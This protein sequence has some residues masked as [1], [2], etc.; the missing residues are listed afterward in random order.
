MHFQITC[1][2]PSCGKEGIPHP[3]RT[4]EDYVSFVDLAPTILEAVGLTW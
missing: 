2:W 1:P 4:V 3:G